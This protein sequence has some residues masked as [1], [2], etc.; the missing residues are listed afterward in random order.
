[1]TKKIGGVIDGVLLLAV[2]IAIGW[3]VISGEY[4]Q[5]LNPRFKWV[6]GASALMLMIVGMAQLRYP[7]KPLKATRMII[8][9]AL[10]GLLFLKDS[11]MV[12]TLAMGDQPGGGS[13]I[14]LN[15]VEYV[16]INVGELQYLL[17]KRSPNQKE[18]PEAATGN[19]VIRG[20]VQHHPDLKEK[21]QFILM[22]A[23][24]WCCLADAAGTGFRVLYDRLGDFKDDEWIQVF[25]HLKLL[26]PEPEP[27]FLRFGWTLT[28][29]VNK[30]Y[31]IVPDRIVK[32]PPPNVTYVFERNTKEPFNY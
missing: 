22:R 2:G 6:T 12:T 13:R 16:K 32:I 18:E 1:M 8:L 7:S 15:G 24:V 11:S 17:T 30:D 10:L 14:P 20:V 25:G 9:T 23:V 27:L 26:R 5:L 28:S 19:Y 3:F 31:A 21:G 29:Y 4:W